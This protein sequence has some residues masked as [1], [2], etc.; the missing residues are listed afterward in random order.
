MVQ[1]R[2]VPVIF[3]EVT[4]EGE[5]AGEIQILGGNGTY[6]W[7]HRLERFYET[8]L[9]EVNEQDV[10]LSTHSLSANISVWNCVKQ[11]AT[12]SGEVK[13][14]VEGSEIYQDT[15]EFQPQWL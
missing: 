10:D 1:S 3:A 15:F 12:S 9:I 14:L 11:M 8:P 6:Y 2:P 13:F 7:A 4:R 5:T